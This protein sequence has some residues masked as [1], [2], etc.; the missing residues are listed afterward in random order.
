MDGMIEYVQHM[1]A[2]ALSP[3]HSRDDIGLGAMLVGWFSEGVV[4]PGHVVRV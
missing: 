1:L 3:Y 4:D 2:T